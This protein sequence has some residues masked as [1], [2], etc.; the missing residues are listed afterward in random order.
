[1]EL[2]PHH[3]HLSDYWW[4]LSLSFCFSSP[5]TS[6]PDRSGWVTLRRGEGL[7]SPS[8]APVQALGGARCELHTSQQW[9]PVC[10][11]GSVRQCLQTVHGPF[12]APALQKL[13]P[14][15]CAHNLIQHA[16][17]VCRSPDSS[18]L[19][20]TLNLFS[21]ITLSGDV[22]FLKS[23]PTHRQVYRHSNSHVK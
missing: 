18:C 2:Y 12:T 19:P 3:S 17:S 9:Q 21:D 23:V 22:S 10:S 11:Y 7:P 8:W 5:P 4:C 16:K 15:L 6:Q 20:N 1:M 13:P 14:E